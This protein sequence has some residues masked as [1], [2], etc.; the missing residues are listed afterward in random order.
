MLIRSYGGNFSIVLSK[1]VVQQYHE[2]NYILYWSILFRISRTILFLNRSLGEIGRHNSKVHFTMAVFL[3][4]E[5][6]PVA[7]PYWEMVVT[8]VCWLAPSGGR[9]RS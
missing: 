4:P 1:E 7:V 9:T 2:Y 8:G 5:T 6:D 3:D